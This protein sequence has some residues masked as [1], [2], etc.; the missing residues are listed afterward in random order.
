MSI[1]AFLKRCLMQYFMVTTCVTVAIAVLGM[2]LDPEARFGYNAYFSPLIFSF[3][4]LLPSLVLYSRREIPFR[5]MMVRK[6]LQI[7]LLEALLIAFVF[8]TG[9]LH[10]FDDTIFFAIAVLIVYLAVNFIE[11]HMDSKEA[12]E[13]NK[14]LKSMQATEHS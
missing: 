1:K 14:T 13:I 6:V 7:I 8:W 11:W 12:N 5:R 10:D 2:S 4:G 3:I 9:L